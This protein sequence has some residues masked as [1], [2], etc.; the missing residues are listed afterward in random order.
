MKQRYVAIQFKHRYDRDEW[1][2]KLYHYKTVLKDLKKDDLVVIETQNGY[3]VARVVRY[4]PNSNLA[5]QYVIQKVDLQEHEELLEKEMK[6]SFLRAEI[7]ERA[8][9]IRE[10]QELEALAKEDEKMKR[11]MA[12]MDELLS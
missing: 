9:A 4:L 8:E 2:S 12:E 10:R 3:S 7:E 5:H 11:L 6:A 1:G